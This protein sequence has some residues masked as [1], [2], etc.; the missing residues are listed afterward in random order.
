MLLRTPILSQMIQLAYFFS[1]PSVDGLVPLKPAEARAL[2][3]FVLTLLFGLRVYT[4]HWVGSIPDKGKVLQ[5][6]GE[7]KGFQVKSQ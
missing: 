6:G 3:G 1:D 4:V 2:G 7:K 5:S